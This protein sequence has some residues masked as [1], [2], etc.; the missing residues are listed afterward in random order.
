MNY[1]LKA[2]WLLQY[3]TIYK[4]TFIFEEIYNLFKD[5]QQHGC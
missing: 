5:I 4:D 1:N 3:V 2:T